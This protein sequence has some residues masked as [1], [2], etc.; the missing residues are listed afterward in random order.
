MWSRAALDVSIYSG[1][2]HV[3]DLTLP[4]LKN[5]TTNI[6]PTLKTPLHNSVQISK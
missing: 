3:F 6:N 4:V 1:E 5:P 2:K